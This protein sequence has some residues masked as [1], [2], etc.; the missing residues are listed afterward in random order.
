MTDSD[1]VWLSPKHVS[2]ATLSSKRSRS[3]TPT[4]AHHIM[5]CVTKNLGKQGNANILVGTVL[6]EHTFFMYT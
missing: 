2:M 3:T 4:A 6:T 1:V 5:D